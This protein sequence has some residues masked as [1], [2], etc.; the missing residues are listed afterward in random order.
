MAMLHGSVGKSGIWHFLFNRNFDD[1]PS[2]M[3]LLNPRYFATCNQA[4]QIPGL[5]NFDGLSSIVITGQTYYSHSLG[6]ISSFKLA[7]PRILGFNGKR[8]NYEPGQGYIQI[9][10]EWNQL[11][12]VINRIP[13]A[14]SPLFCF[15]KYLGL[16][17]WSQSFKERFTSSAQIFGT[18]NSYFSRNVFRD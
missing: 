6:N 13:I 18:G 14:F 16:K 11:I 2:H 1:K 7:Y 9:S 15:A 17:G 4:Y 12:L 3:V 5:A 10:N 8:I